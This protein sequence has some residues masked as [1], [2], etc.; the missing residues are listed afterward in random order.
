MSYS[1]A[2][3]RSVLPRRA[4]YPDRRRIGACRLVQESAATRFTFSQRV[5]G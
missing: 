4:F 2:D 3:R 5:A 1:G